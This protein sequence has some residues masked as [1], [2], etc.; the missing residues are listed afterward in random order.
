MRLD[1]GFIT[2]DQYLS[3]ALGMQTRRTRTDLYFASYGLTAITEIVV[4][5]LLSPRSFALRFGALGRGLDIQI[6]QLLIVIEGQGS[7]TKA[8]PQWDYFGETQL[9]VHDWTG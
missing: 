5:Q 9:F 1:D 8:S 6:E 2:S 4:R 7:F 3:F